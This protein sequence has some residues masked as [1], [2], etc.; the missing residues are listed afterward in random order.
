VLPMLDARSPAWPRRSFSACRSSA[1]KV[2]ADGCGWRILGQFQAAPPA[3]DLL[4][5]STVCGRDAARCQHLLD[6]TQAQ[7]EPEIQPDRVAYELAGVAIASTRGAQ[8]RHPR[9]KS[10]HPGSA[11]REAAQ[12]DGAR[13]PNT[14][15]CGRG[16]AV[17]CSLIPISRSIRRSAS[18]ET[19][20]VILLWR[21]GAALRYR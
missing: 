13:D 19:S 2:L 17:R 5:S 15:W 10:G 6:H 3:V 8:R 1:R 9:Q 20:A 11:K 12:V 18:C 4:R 14:R 21:R 16:G 7:R